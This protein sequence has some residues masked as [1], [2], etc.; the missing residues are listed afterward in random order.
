MN[1]TAKDGYSKKSYIHYPFFEGSKSPAAGIHEFKKI[2]LRAWSSDR[3][4]T[5][6]RDAFAHTL[7]AGK[8]MEMQDY[9]LCVLFIDGEYW[10]LH[11]IRESI[12]N[13]YYFEQRYGIN[14]ENPGVDIIE[15]WSAAAEGDMTYYNA[16]ITFLQNNSLSDTANYNFIKTWID[17]PEAMLYFIACTYMMK[18]DWP[19]QN[20]ACW[21]PRT[22]DGKWRWLQWDMDNSMGF[23]YYSDF[24]Q[25]G[26][27]I[28]GYWYP[29]HFIFDQLITS[30]AFV[31]D[32]VNMY[33]DYMNTE[34]LPGVMIA[35]L[36]SM[37]G[38][39]LPYMPEFVDRWQLNY[40]WQTQ[41]DYLKWIL[42]T[43]PSYAQQYVRT[44]FGLTGQDTVTMNVNDTA[45][46]N[47]KISTLF[48]DE[49][50]TRLTPQ[51]YPWKGIYFHDVPVPIKA[52]AKQGYK[53]SHWLETGDT[54][55]E[56]KF[57]LTSDS[58]FTAVFEIDS[59]QIPDVVDV[60]A[61]EAGFRIFP[62]PVQDFLIIHQT[63]VNDYSFFI[64]DL[65][66]KKVLE[67]K[68]SNEINHVEVISTLPP[69]IYLLNILSDGKTKQLKFVKQ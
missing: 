17:I 34:F 65:L 4:Y 23:S 56:L 18:S 27:L 62:N 26:A 15:T 1:I 25:L 49:N 60:I 48:L 20:E 42:D 46:G 11:E 64:S 54:I 32:F 6:L 29:A 9:K 2:V 3:Q 12:K 57:Y 68:T 22:P 38:E 13:G 21:R 40:D 28:N 16:M 19:N 47:V 53:F 66:G 35:H 30:Q 36:D 59:S 50:T 31:H 52:V 69:G 5:M 39:M 41:I 55:P 33:A 37:V 7:L 61:E 67:T 45:M 8:D 63:K 24:D 14:H 43:R 10:G 44:N 58:Q 51:T